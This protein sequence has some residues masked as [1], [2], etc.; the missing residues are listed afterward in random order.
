MASIHKKSEDQKDQGKVAAPAAG[1]LR[2]C[3]GSSLLNGVA[4][5]C[6]VGE[7]SLRSSEV[8]LEPN[9]SVCTLTAVAVALGP[10][11]Y[12]TISSLSPAGKPSLGW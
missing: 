6:T 8:L 11:S 2:P 3:H 9:G 10:G 7:G 1:D 12:P 5:M 4:L